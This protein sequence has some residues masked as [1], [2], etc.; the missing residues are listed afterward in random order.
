MRCTCRLRI[1]ELELRHP[2]ASGSSSRCSRPNCVEWEWGFPSAIQSYRGT[3]AGFGFRLPRKA[4][5]YFSLYS[6]RTIPRAF[7]QWAAARRR[8]HEAVGPS[9]QLRIMT[10]RRLRYVA[11]VPG[12]QDQLLGHTHHLVEVLAQELSIAA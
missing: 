11:Q 6:R 4:A 10:I 9:A 7:L 8:V 12:T 1:T 5:P 3:M 2:T